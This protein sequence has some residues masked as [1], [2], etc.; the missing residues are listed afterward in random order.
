MQQDQDKYHVDF[1][2]QTILFVDDEVDVLKAL[3][4]ALK[5]EPYRCLFTQSG[6]QALNLLEDQSIGALVSDLRMPHMDGMTVFRHVEKTRP[7]VVRLVLSGRS[8]GV[9]VAD[10]VNQSHI[11]HYIIKPWDDDELKIILRN[12]LFM[13]HLQQ[14]RRRL[15][16]RLEEQ[17]QDLEQKVEQRTQQLLKVRSQAEIGKYAAQIVHNLRNPLHAAGAGVD[18]FELMLKDGAADVEAMTK[19]IGLVRE[20]LGDLKQII[21]GILNHARD[22]GQY[23]LEKVDI[24]AVIRQELTFFDLSPFFK[25]SVTKVVQ[26]DEAL[27]HILGSSTQFKQILDNLVSNAVDAMARSEVRQLT[28]RTQSDEHAVY[29]EVAD[30]GEGIASG[31]LSRIFSGGFTTK[32]MG[33]GTGIGLSSVKRIVSTYGGEIKVDSE[34]GQGTAFH[35]S[36]PIKQEKHLADSLAGISI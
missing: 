24:N 30:T 1:S 26:L 14:E 10:A 28:V 34:P 11:Y 29:I 22:E 9:A 36:F 35:L 17:N 4:R 2:D 31:N 18:L 12:A 20:S 15:I 25:R 7:D 21:G 3:Q 13:R 8:D 23:F 27:P 16:E 5:P 33:V 19:V 6:R 32:P